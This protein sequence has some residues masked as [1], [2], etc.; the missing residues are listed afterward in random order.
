MIN[1][2]SPL[3]KVYAIRNWVPGSIDAIGMLTTPKMSLNLSVVVFIEL[4]RSEYAKPKTLQ[5]LAITYY[6]YNA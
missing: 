6:S 1:Y 4:V 3:N 5:F 2:N